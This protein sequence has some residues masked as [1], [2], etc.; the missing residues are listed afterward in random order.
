MNRSLS[1]PMAN[2]HLPSLTR[3]HI[4][5]STSFSPPHRLHSPSSLFIR[6]RR[7]SHPLTRP[8]FI[9][10]RCSLHPNWLTVAVMS[11]NAWFESALLPFIPHGP[12]PHSRC[13][14]SPPTSQASQSSPPPLMCLPSPSP[15]NLSC[16]SPHPLRCGMSL[17]PHQLAQRLRR[18]RECV[19]PEQ[20]LPPYIT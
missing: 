1:T 19:H 16:S 5:H 13:S 8:T 14:P 7:L 15:H 12:P 10:A 6:R 20:S 17:S 2:G 18:R 11:M 9:T 3:R 4:S